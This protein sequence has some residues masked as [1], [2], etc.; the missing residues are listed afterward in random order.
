MTKIKNLNTGD[1]FVWKGNK[2]QVFFTLKNPPKKAYKVAVI[3]W[4]MPDG[5]YWFPS[6][7]L[8][9]PIIRISI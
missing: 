2:Y 9:K 3:D 8:V 5:S 4:P 7:R 6:A 1:T